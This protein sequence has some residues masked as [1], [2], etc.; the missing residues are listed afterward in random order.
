[1]TEQGKIVNRGAGGFLCPPEHPEHTFSVETDLRCRPE[2]RGSMSLSYAVDC[3]WLDPRTRVASYRKLQDWRENRINLHMSAVK[4]WIHQVLGYFRNS[5]RGQDGGKYGRGPWAAESL[6]ITKDVD[7]MRN[8]RL[9][10]GIHFIH[11]YYPEYAPTQA[12]FT[13]AYWGKKKG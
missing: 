9:H 4:D 6:R 11:Q 8:L 13:A 1:M 2:N 12:D 5:Y 10:A 7:P 3:D